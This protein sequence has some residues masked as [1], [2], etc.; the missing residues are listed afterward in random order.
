[1]IQHGT[2]RELYLSRAIVWSGGSS[3]RFHN[4]TM[5]RFAKSPKS[6]SHQAWGPVGPTCRVLGGPVTIAIDGNMSVLAA[7]T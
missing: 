7:I 4:F 5:C 3:V 6:T 2:N 1:M